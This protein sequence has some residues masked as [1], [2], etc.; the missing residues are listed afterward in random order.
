MTTLNYNFI[1][2]LLVLGLFLKST[3]FFPQNISTIF[4]KSQILFSSLWL[5]VSVL[6]ENERKTEGVISASWFFL[7]KDGTKQKAKGQ[8]CSGGFNANMSQFIKSLFVPLVFRYWSV[9]CFKK[10]KSHISDSNSEQKTNKMSSSVTTTD[11][12]RLPGFFFCDW[13]QPHTKTHSHIEEEGEGGEE[14]PEP[15]RLG[16]GGR[17]FRPESAVIG[18]RVCLSVTAGLCSS[19]A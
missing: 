16:E 2:I 19:R 17:S 3:D 1:H 10:E 11:H 9:S 12:R 14:K 18:G 4:S 5:R 8:S 13:K 7:C 15:G 6:P